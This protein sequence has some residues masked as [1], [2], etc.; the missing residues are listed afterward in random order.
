MTFDPQFLTMM[1]STV[2]VAPL[3]ASNDYGEAVYSTAYASYRCR[4]EYTPV[5]VRNSLGE[6]VVSRATV[7][8]ASTTHLPMLAEYSIPNGSGDWD[9]P[10]VQNIAVHYDEDGVHHNVV[11]L[12]AGGG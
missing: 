7:Y 2:R 3:T 9:T 12:G 1:P 10:E 6:E 4:I 11:Y 8:V 5:V